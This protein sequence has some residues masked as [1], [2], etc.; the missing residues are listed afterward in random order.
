MVA[1]VK[2]QKGVLVTDPAQTGME[3]QVAQ[4]KIK[5]EL[6]GTFLRET[7]VMLWANPKVVVPEG[8]Q[9]VGQGRP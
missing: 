4:D 3:I 8:A 7:R 5:A 1:Q 9:I 2:G 6:Q